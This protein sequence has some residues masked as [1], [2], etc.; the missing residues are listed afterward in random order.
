MTSKRIPG[1]AIGAWTHA[2]AGLQVG[3]NHSIHVL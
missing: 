1:L 2:R 3:S